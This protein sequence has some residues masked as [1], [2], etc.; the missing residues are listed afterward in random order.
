MNNKGQI[1]GEAEE[2]PMAARLQNSGITWV[3]LIAVVSRLDQALS[4]YYRDEG[5]YPALWVDGEF[6]NLN[7]QIVK[8]P[9][10]DRLE[11]A[12]DINDHGWIVGGGRRR[13][14]S[15]ALLLKPIPH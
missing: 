9:D 4:P 10:W 5:S 1:I 12:T 15:R 3:W 13:G 14:K 2:M 7:D 11:E 6:F 8:S